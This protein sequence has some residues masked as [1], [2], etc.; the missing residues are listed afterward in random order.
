M[1]KAVTKLADAGQ[2]PGLKLVSQLKQLSGVSASGISRIA[3]EM[4]RLA[5]TAREG[6]A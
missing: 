2:N 3:D 6:D 4:G 5:D 1:A